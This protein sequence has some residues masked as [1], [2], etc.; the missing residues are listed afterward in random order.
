M[1]KTIQLLSIACVALFLSVGA[2][3]RG[4]HQTADEWRV[5][6]GGEGVTG[7]AE[8]WRSKWGIIAKIRAEGLQEGYAYTVWV[9]GYNRPWHCLGGKGACEGPDLIG[10]FGAQSG[11]RPFL[12]IGTGRLGNPAGTITDFLIEAQR[13]KAGVKGRQQLILG[14][15]QNP[16]GAEILLVIRC[17]GPS[18]FFDPTNNGNLKNAFDQTTT[19][20]G[21]CHFTE[22]G[23]NC[24]DV[25]EIIFR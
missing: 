14:E 15:V 8:I 1:L 18:L 21:G 12:F 6:P 7:H 16:M 17:H 11:V 13:G 3:A 9:G 25:A 24:V 5:L 4:K 2:E 20:E 23:S 22:E 10:G 19:W